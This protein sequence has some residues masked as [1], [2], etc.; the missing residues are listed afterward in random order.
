VAEQG[1]NVGAKKNLPTACAC[2]NVEHATASTHA[3]RKG[4]DSLCNDGNAGLDGRG[5]PEVFLVQNAA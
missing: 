1:F 2:T 4:I 5:Y 3:L